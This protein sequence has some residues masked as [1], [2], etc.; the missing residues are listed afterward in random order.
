MWY[1]LGVKFGCR[2]FWLSHL[3]IILKLDS[4]P[5]NV[6]LALP[7]TGFLIDLCSGPHGHTFIFLSWIL[8]IKH[9]QNVIKYQHYLEVGRGKNDSIKDSMYYSTMYVVFILSQASNIFWSSCVPILERNQ[10]SLTGWCMSL[11]LGSS[12]MSCSEHVGF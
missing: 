11:L 1:Y 8:V 5:W 10:M 3:H 4:N 6:P 7:C 2:L 12:A 9:Q